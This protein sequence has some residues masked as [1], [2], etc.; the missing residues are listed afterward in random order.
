MKRKLIIILGCLIA[1]PILTAATFRIVYHYSWQEVGTTFK[2]IS[3]IGTDPVDYTPIVI[4]DTSSIDFSSTIVRFERLDPTHNDGDQ[5]YFVTTGSQGQLLRTPKSSLTFPFSSITSVPAYITASSTNTLTNKS[6]NISQWTNN[7]GYLTSIS[8]S[9]VTTALGYTPYNSTNPNG[10]ITASVAVTL[11][12]KAGLISQWTNNSG[13]I[14]GISGGDVTSALGYTPVTNARSLTINGV[15]YDL[16]ADRSWSIEVVPPGTVTEYAGT[17]A[18]SGYLL[19]DGSAVSRTTYSALFTA[20][21]TTYGVGDGSATFNV[22]DTRQ[23]FPLGKA[24]SGTGATLGSSGGTVDH[25][26]TVDP[27]ST[28][29]GTPSGTSGQLVGVINVASADHTHSVNIAEFNS[30]TANPP[31]LVFN[32]II[33]Y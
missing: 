3:S 23:R 22:P 14:T 24:S 12:N 25:L 18:P 1:L 2:V 7:T 29:S 9:D 17:S 11:T 13:Y 31:Y 28:T 33:K 6:G 20:I 16:T 26:H 30:G 19:C 32:Y 10:Y 4:Q 27:P 15:A 5:D 21:G 8:G